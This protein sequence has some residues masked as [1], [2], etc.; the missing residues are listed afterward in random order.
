MRCPMKAMQIN[1]ATQGPILISAEVPKPEPGADGVL[2]RVRA[3]GVT[4][5]EL[6]WYP[7]T[8]DKEG[9][10]R[11]RAVPSHEFSGTIAALG[12]DVKGLE[13]GDEVYGMNDW[14]VEGAA[15]E[16]CLTLPKNISAKPTALTHEAAAT[17]PIAALT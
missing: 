1:S 17:V 3:A 7:T 9:S 11:T 5:T 15:A 4:P 14:F 2:I 12:R 13:I 8:H 16:Y 6:L 10:I